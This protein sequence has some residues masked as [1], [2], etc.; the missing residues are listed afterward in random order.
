[1]SFISN[2]HFLHL[3][4]NIS[5]QYFSYQNKLFYLQDCTRGS[6]HI[7]VWV[8]SFTSLIVSQYSHSTIDEHER[9]AQELEVCCGTEQSRLIYVISLS[10][11]SSFAKGIFLHVQTLKWLKKDSVC[12]KMWLSVNHW[13]CQQTRGLVVHFPSTWTQASLSKT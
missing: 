10:R 5:P 2:Y 11:Q 9:Q 12:G 13:G 1:M 8:I 7:C 3:I 6:T 4:T